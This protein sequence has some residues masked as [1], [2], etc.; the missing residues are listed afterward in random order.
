MMP[1]AQKPVRPAGVFGPAA[2]SEAWLGF[3]GV[4]QGTLQGCIFFT[5]LGHLSLTELEPLRERLH[6]ASQ[7][8]G[9]GRDALPGAVTGLR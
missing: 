2:A 5:Q 1:A 4:L 7:V 8:V 3:A 9:H 6:L